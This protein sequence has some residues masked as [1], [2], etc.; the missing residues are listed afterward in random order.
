MR[1][2]KKLFPFFF[3]TD[4][5]LEGQHRSL[6]KSTW[7][8]LLLQKHLTLL[9]HLKR[10]GGGI[11]NCAKKRS[12]LCGRGSAS[13]HFHTSESVTED[14]GDRERKGERGRWRCREGASGNRQ[15]SRWRKYG[16]DSPRKK[17]K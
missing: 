6:P 4:W 15:K 3:N 17:K 9:F 13:E 1:T 14:G 11:C 8:K 5:E 2:Q 7:N 16:R 10:A 12:N